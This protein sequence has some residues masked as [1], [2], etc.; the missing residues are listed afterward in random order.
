[1]FEPERH[2]LE[3]HLR[4]AIEEVF[5]ESKELRGRT[6]KVGIKHLEPIRTLDILGFLR[7]NRRSSESESVKHHTLWIEFEDFI[8]RILDRL[9]KLVILEFVLNLTNLVLERLLVVR[10]ILTETVKDLWSMPIATV[11]Y[12]VITLAADL[13]DI[14]H[15]RVHL[16]LA[17]DYE[18]ISR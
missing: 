7:L 4:R 12:R 17:I 5:H 9:R 8:R 16:A 6:A 1:M 2:L 15:L 14:D 13:N 3:S 11:S 10:I 18:Y